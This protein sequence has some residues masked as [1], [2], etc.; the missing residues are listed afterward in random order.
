MQSS[1]IQTRDVHISNDSIMRI[2]A[3]NTAADMVVK[4]PSDKLEDFMAKVNHLGIYVNASTMDIEDRTLDNLSV[5]LKLKDRQRT[6][7]PAKTRQNQN[8]ESYRCTPIKG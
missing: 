4:I 8:K 3:Y 2:A 5:R 1:A 7:E 6:G